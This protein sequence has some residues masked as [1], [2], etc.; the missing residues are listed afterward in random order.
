MTQTLPVD[1]AS[2]SALPPVPRGQ[3]PSSRRA[4]G[5]SVAVLAVY[6]GAWWAAAVL[7]HPLAWIAAWW[8]MGLVLSGA[9]AAMHDCAH[10]ILFGGRRANEVFGRLWALAIVMN[11]SQYRSLHLLHHART[12]TDDDPEPRVDLTSVPYYAVV[13]VFGG[14]YFVGQ[15]TYEAVAMLFG[16]FPSY[17]TGERR[18]R[19][20]RIDSVIL[21]VVLAVIVAVTIEWPRVVLTVWLVPFMV[22]NVVFMASTSLA[23]HYGCRRD[24]DV[25]QVTRTV[26]SNRFARFFLW[27]GNYHV[28]HHWAPH[29]PYFGLPELRV[30]LA[31]HCPNV[32]RS[33][34]S[35]H[36]HLLRSI[37][38]DR[39]ARRGAAAR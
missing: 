11:F 29:V 4:T 10:K 20:A 12:A 25:F 24:A 35:F 16:R 38:A 21:L 22:A 3:R 33:Y 30:L 26:L 2:T 14:I 34:S 36:W 19:A 13:M 8:V 17:V 18:R 7:H 1:H 5:H 31:E 28:E 39:R 37:R 9:F 27:N 15:I 23:E 32:E 6:M